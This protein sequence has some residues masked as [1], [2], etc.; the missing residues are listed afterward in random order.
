M[1]YSVLFRIWQ[2]FMLAQYVHTVWWLSVRNLFLQNQHVTIPLNLDHFNDLKVLGHQNWWFLWGFR[3]LTKRALFCSTSVDTYK[4]CK[5]F[6]NSFCPVVKSYA[7]LR[8][9]NASEKLRQLR[10]TIFCAAFLL[11]CR[12][13]YENISSSVQEP[14][15]FQ[16]KHWYS[17]QYNPH[18]FTYFSFKSIF[19]VEPIETCACNVSFSFSRVFMSTGSRQFKQFVKNCF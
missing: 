17:L 11:H 5:Q 14:N 10:Q 18:F 13:G 7:F 3:C 19:Y 15:L 9:L 8:M 2:S 6:W 4:D 16:C 12:K 1:P